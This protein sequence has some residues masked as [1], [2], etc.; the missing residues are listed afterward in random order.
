VQLADFR[1]AALEP[2]ESDWAELREAQTMTLSKLPNT[3]QAVITDLGESHDIHPRNKLG[4]ARRLA[5]WAL[6]KDYGFD[7]VYHSPQYKSHEV[8]DNKVVLTF[9]HV[10]G[11]LDTFDIRTPIGFAIA[12]EDK[13]FVWA[14]AKIVGKDRIEVWAEGISEPVSVRYA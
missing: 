11:G 3:G 7:I 13:E 2:Q 5:R 9:D 1:D 10:G 12:A 4:V 14:Q 6:A 8:K